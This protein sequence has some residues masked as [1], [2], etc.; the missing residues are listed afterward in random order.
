MGAQSVAIAGAGNMGRA[1]IS[2][3]LR[4][5]MLPEDIRVAEVSADA[6]ASL[7][8]DF[9]VG[10]CED[11]RAAIAGAA[12]MVI[13]VKPQEVAALLAPLQP[14]LGQTRPV[15]IS[16]AAGI[17]IA[18]L[19][20]WCGANVPVLRAMPN[21]PAFV[22]AGVTGVFAGPEVSRSARDT[23][24]HVLSAVGEI[25]WLADEASLDVVTALS[26]SGPAYL[27]LLTE[28][29]MQAAVALGLE[30]EAARRLAVGTLYGSGQLAQSGDGDLARLRH[31]VTS[32][33][34]TTEAALEVFAAA[35]LG[36]IVLRALEAATQRGRELARQFG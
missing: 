32:K 17:R 15:V 27:F 31:D 29:M 9:A 26:G 34:G 36:G 23:A 14:L 30:G 2:A 7:T 22:G 16:I 21:R 3:L 19:K 5:G 12:V 4:R 10:A 6:R 13:A 1:L 33:G 18:S 24:A 28:A 20:S 25:V 8:R 11:A 35:D